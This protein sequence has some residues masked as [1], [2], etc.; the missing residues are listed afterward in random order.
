MREY[1]GLIKLEE[2]F[3][4]KVDSPFYVNMNLK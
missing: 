2:P 4:Q 3:G 1:I